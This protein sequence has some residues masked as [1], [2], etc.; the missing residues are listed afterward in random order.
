MSI[1][2]VLLKSGENIITDVKELVSDEKVCG[3]LF[4]KPYLVSTRKERIVIENSDDSDTMKNSS[5]IQ[6]SLSPWIILSK[7]TQIPINMEY[8]VTFV[9]PVE[10][11][12][13]MY[14]GSVNEQ[15]S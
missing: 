8:V 4:D 14:E 6:I 12:K 3:Y 5:Q 11:L 7:D 15:N 10:S 9:E 13:E 1:K 2:L